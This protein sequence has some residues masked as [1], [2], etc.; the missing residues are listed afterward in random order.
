MCSGHVWI[1]ALSL[2]NKPSKKKNCMKF[3]NQSIRK[4]YCGLKIVTYKNLKQNK[5]STPLAIG[6]YVCFILL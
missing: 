6:D 4:S 1:W 3:E 2:L 5:A